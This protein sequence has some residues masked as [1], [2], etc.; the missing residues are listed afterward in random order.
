M[1]ILSPMSG[2]S[3]MP[4][5][6]IC[7]EYGSAMSYT[8]FVSAA[9]MSYNNPQT[10]RFFDFAPPERP[11]VFQFFDSDVERLVTQ[12]RRAEEMF[13]PDIIDINMGCS[14]ASVSGRGAGAGL[15]RT[16]AKIAQIFDRLSR[17]LKVPVTGKIRL[18][19]DETSR[20]Y[21]EVA[22]IL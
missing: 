10:W 8:E 17:E 13:Q 2:F 15:L 11:M 16:P 5:R 7:R 22:H 6:S 1:L 4:F 12:C 14:E 9:A 21:L 3:D 20:N 19:W 18:G